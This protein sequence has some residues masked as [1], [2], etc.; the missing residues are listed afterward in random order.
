MFFEGIKGN[1]EPKDLNGLRNILISG[2]A[3]SI[4]ALAVG[5][6]QS[7]SGQLWPGFSPLLMCVFAVT[8]ISVVAGIWGGKTIGSRAGR[9]AEIAGGFIL[10]LIGV[11]ILLG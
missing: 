4:D 1:E 3:T 5:V 2:I 6:S 7:M 11:G 9:L 8:A 10:V